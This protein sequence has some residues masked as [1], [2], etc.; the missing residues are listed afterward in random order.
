MRDRAQR[1]PVHEVGPREVAG[2][3]RV[4]AVDG[5]PLRRSVA[6]DAEDRE[7]LGSAGEL[8]PGQRRTPIARGDCVLDRIGLEQRAAGRDPG[9]VLEAGGLD[10]HGLAPLRPLFLGD[11]EALERVLEGAVSQGQLQLH[12]HARGRC[13][14][15]SGQHPRPEA[16]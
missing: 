4:L 16:P 14:L 5:V 2:D 6:I 11:E 1:E 12:G 7:G 10:T 3:H 8:L 13:V 9:P 15:T